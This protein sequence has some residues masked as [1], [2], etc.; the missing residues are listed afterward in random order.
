MAGSIGMVGGA[1]VLSLPLF[2]IGL[3][4]GHELQDIV[5]RAA[6]LTGNI[7]LDHLIF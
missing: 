2:M 6:T 5:A 3:Q 7:D 1:V 4:H